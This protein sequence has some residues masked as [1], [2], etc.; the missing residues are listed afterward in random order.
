MTNEDQGGRSNPADTV[1]SLYNQVAKVT[2]HTQEADHQVGNSFI[3]ASSCHLSVASL[4]GNLRWIRLQYNSAS[5][6]NGYLLE[7]KA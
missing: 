3:L 5:K 4:H 1:N 2:K 6:G 7:T